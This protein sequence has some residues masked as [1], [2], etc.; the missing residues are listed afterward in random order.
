VSAGAVRSL[1]ARHGL[2]PN[3]ELG[4]NFLVDEHLAARLVEQ[5]GVAPGDC[6]IEIGAGLGVLTRALA[7][8]AA[9]VIALEIDA[10]L[11]RAL[12]AEG[13]LPAN[14]ELLHADALETDLAALARG[15]A[16]RVRLVANLPYAVSS[17]LLRRLLAARRALADWSVM[18]QREVADRIA[19]KPGG[20]DFGSLAVLHA[21]TVRVE[22]GMRLRPGC[23]F[24]APKVESC[25]LRMT[26]RADSPLVVDARGDELERVERVA[27]AA[28]ATRRKR[29]ANALRTD[30]ALVAGCD[31]E[32]LLGRLGI[33]PDARAE[34]LPPETFLALSRALEAAA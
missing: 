22:R 26:P 34:V 6:V 10:G 17:P 16:G 5:A 12:R 11:V 13:G 20:R 9:R 14:V 21:L 18:L 15:A 25:V 7:A 32:A 28:F 2:R 1:L 29:L 4:Q 31:L 33:D 23:F 30:A 3:R 19:A 8:R 24:P 27:R